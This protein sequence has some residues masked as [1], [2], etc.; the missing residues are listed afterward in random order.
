MPLFVFEVVKIITVE[1]VGVGLV[2]FQLH[3]QGAD[4]VLGI[5]TGFAEDFG[6]GIFP[7]GRPAP[8]AIGHFLA[9]GDIDL[10]DAGRH[11]FITRQGEGFDDD[12]RHGVNILG[13]GEDRQT[14]GGNDS[15][16]KSERD[17]GFCFHN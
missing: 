14:S 12:R 9:E 1:P 17:D 3:A 5:V 15:A 11:G 16:D 2:R 8:G 4:L 13:L 7:T 6:C 10:G